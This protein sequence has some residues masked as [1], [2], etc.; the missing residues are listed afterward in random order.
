MEAELQL[1]HQAESAA[2]ART[3]LRHFL[4]DTADEGVDADVALLVVTELVS[5]AV[6]HTRAESGP[7]HLRVDLRPAVL[8]AEVDDGDPSA[9]VRRSSPSEDHQGRGLTMVAGMAVGWGWCRR[10]REGK[11]VWCDVSRSTAAA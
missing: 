8:H 7:I 4:S 3:F 5:N 1:G 2:V 9:P 6:R 11:R 10:V